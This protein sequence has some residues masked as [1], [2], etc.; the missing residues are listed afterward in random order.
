MRMKCQLFKF[1]LSWKGEGI[2][3]K[4]FDKLDKGKR[5]IMGAGVAVAIVLLLTL[6]AWGIYVV[7]S[8]PQDTV[9]KNNEG[10][11]AK[12]VGQK[13]SEAKKDD[14]KASAKKDEDESTE[15]KDGKDEGE[16][17]VAK[18]VTGSD[19]KEKEPTEV[20]ENANAVPQGTGTAASS[21][22]SNPT[23]NTTSQ[24]NGNSNQTAQTQGNTTQKQDTQQQNN[25]QQNPPASTVPVEST[26]PAPTEQ[27]K[28]EET[29]VWVNEPVYE[30]R[31]V[32]VQ[33]AWDEPIQVPV[34]EQRELSV[35][36]G[37][38]ADITNNIDEHL[39][40][41]MLAGNYAC[42]GYHSEVV[43]VQVGTKDDI[44]HHDEVKRLEP[45][46]IADGYWE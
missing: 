16:K 11:D 40:S 17:D 7:T 23:K 6:G 33:E 19:A 41:N 18:D 13:E 34:Y 38:G 25:Q 32:V 8:K 24:G 3:K 31:W 12:G 37:C 22:P 9:A 1:C 28:Q 36:N 27:P 46:K 26:T 35:C 15:I 2:M 10:M 20:V 5:R 43:S 14:K 39:K 44:I 45:V 42:G 30:D 4:W 21:A 29:R